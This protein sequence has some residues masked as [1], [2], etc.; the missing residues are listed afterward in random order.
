MQKPSPH[1]FTIL[2]GFKLMP[3]HQNG[4]NPGHDLESTVQH[5]PKLACHMSK[6]LPEKS[7]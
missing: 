7:R 1:G 2:D 6:G 5:L 3:S 4:P